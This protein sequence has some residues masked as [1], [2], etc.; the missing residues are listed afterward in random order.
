MNAL[1]ATPGSGATRDRTPKPLRPKPDPSWSWATAAAFRNIKPKLGFS[2]KTQSSL[3]KNKLQFSNWQ[4]FDPLPPL[5]PPNIGLTVFA[6]FLF[7][8]TFCTRLDQDTGSASLWYQQ[9]LT[10]W[11]HLTPWDNKW[12]YYSLSSTCIGEAS[13]QNRLWCKVELPFWAANYHWK[14]KMVNSVNFVLYFTN[15]LK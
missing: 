8:L 12:L 5:K 15:I 3:T 4:T 6:L 9:D 7:G 1:G 2:V 14:G 13:Q 10:Q 11:Q